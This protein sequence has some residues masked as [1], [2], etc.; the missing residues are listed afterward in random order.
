MGATLHR[1][2]T[3]SQLQK[4][5]PANLK[6]LA[7]G[8]DA[9]EPYAVVVFTHQPVRVGDI[10]RAVRKVEPLVGEVLVLAGDDF[11]VEANALA[12]ANHASILAHGHFG[13]TEVTFDAIHTSIASNKKSP[14]GGS[15][16]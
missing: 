16:A 4:I 12:D 8:I 1:R 13:W 6:L 9:P 11:T 2:V 7:A 10:R 14:S 15:A 3:K 5:V